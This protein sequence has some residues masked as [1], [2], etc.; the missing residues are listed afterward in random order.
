MK[1]RSRSRAAPKSCAISGCGNTDERDVIAKA[2]DANK[3]TSAY[4]RYVPQLQLEDGQWIDNLL[5]SSSNASTARRDA[6]A[7]AADQRLP[8]RIMKRFTVDSL[9]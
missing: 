3:V 7:L 9:A 4:I 5:R 6:E 2:P 8:V 1:Q